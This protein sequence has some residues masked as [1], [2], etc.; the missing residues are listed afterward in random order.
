MPVAIVPFSPRFGS[1]RALFEIW[2]TLVF[3]AGALGHARKHPPDVIYQRYNRFNWTGVALS[4][5]LK[6]PLCLEVNG[7]EVWVA[8]NWDP[9]GQVRLLG[10]VERLN[11]RA[12]DRVVVVSSVLARACE[13]SGADPARIVINPNG[14]D[15]ERFRPGVGGDRVRRELGLE[16]RTVAGF[17]GT[18]GPWH[19]VVTLAEAITRLPRDVDVTFL[20][21]GD[22][23]QRSRVERILDEAGA[24]DRVVFTGLIDHGEVAAHLDACDIL[25][26]PHVEMPDGSSFFGSPT[27]LFEYMAMA[28][29]IVASRLGQI[30]DVIEDEVCGLLIRPGAVDELNAAVT[31]L[32][33]DPELRERLGRAARDRVIANYT[34]RR[35]AERVVEAVAE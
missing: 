2:N 4:T 20:L 28:R 5:F 33:H 17:V 7:L 22:G 14:V 29:P 9:V 11:L 19:G 6:R 3:T 10:A 16:G 15:P 34:W 25:L 35:N 21:V 27:K 8:G 32:A 26:S 13:R 12:A 1:V 24:R 30:G 31:R 23:D 18:F